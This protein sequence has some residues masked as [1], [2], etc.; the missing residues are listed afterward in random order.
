M[1][2]MLEFNGL[3]SGA[4]TCIFLILL[5]QTHTHLSPLCVSHQHVSS[6]TLQHTAHIWLCWNPNFGFPLHSK[7]RKKTIQITITISTLVSTSRHSNVL[8]IISTAILC[9]PLYMLKLFKCGHRLAVN[10]SS[11]ISWNNFFLSDS[12]DIILLC[13]YC[14]SSG[15]TLLFFYTQNEKNYIVIIIVIFPGVNGPL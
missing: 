7:L 11:F 14:Y 4:E 2:L 8:F 6:L 10:V 13:H 3:I 5:L 9:L 1:A 15:W 12:S